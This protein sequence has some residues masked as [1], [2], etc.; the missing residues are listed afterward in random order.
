MLTELRGYPDTIH[1]NCAGSTFISFST[2]GRGI[3]TNVEVAIWKRKLTTWGKSL[4]NDLTLTI[5]DEVTVSTMMH[6]VSNF[7]L[8]VRL[9]VVKVLLVRIATR[10]GD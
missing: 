1:C 4:K 5:I 6:A 7:S 9:A 8:A 10:L 3:D 2:V